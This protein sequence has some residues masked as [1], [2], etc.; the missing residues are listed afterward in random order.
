[1]NNE[2]E[3]KFQVPSSSRRALLDE[4]GRGRLPLQ[5][6]TLS[7]AWFALGWLAARTQQVRALAKPELERAVKLRPPKPRR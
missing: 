7:G 1:M 3:L 5:R 6:I 4:L 2:I